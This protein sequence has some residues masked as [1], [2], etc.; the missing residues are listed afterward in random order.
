MPTTIAISSGSLRRAF[1]LEAAITGDRPLYIDGSSFEETDEFGVFIYR[2]T[3]V[4]VCTSDGIRHLC[5]DGDRLRLEDDGAN[6]LEIVEV[7]PVTLN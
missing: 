1:S 5:K 7:Y 6:W 2:G 4:P 3:E